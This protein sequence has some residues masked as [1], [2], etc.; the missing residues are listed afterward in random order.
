M[1]PLQTITALLQGSKWS[2]LLLRIVLQDAISE[3]MTVK[4]PMRVKVFVYDIT[5]RVTEQSEDSPEIACKV[6]KKVNKEIGRTG[7]KL[8]IDAGGKRREQ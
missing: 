2:C 6:L 7:F 3:V 8:S 5:I 1:A 4:T